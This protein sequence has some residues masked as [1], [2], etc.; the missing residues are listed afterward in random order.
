MKLTTKYISIGMVIFTVVVVILTVYKTR[1]FKTNLTKAQKTTIAGLKVVASKF[2]R[3]TEIIADWFLSFASSL[4]K[5]LTRM[6]SQIAGMFQQITL[7]ATRS[8]KQCLFKISA[9]SSEFC[10]IIR[11]LGINTGKAVLS[12]RQTLA[13]KAFSFDQSILV[14]TG[15][16]VGERIS[17]L[18][19]T[20]V[21][22]TKNGKWM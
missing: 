10:Q 12:I 19:R 11:Q 3:F 22:F 16:V 5:T 14:K 18:I 7:A 1:Q 20:L 15:G 21:S 4:K 17:A 2:G 8:L 13:S 9:F 6:I